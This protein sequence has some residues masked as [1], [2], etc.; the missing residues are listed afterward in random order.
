[1]LP[2]KGVAEARKLVDGTAED[3]ATV[4]LSTAIATLTVGETTL[5]LRLGAVDFPDYRAVLTM[6]HQHHFSVGRTDL[7]AAVRRLLVFTTE[8]ARGVKLAIRP[9]LLELSVATGDIGEGTEEVSIAYNGPPITIGFNARYLMDLLVAVDPAERVILDLSE[10][11]TPALLRTEDDDGYRYV[12][13]PM[14]L[15]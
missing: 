5:T 6:P 14:H 15:C 12:V 10:P 9:D 3:M 11:T 1:L 2:A 4:G 7:L 8:R 13:M